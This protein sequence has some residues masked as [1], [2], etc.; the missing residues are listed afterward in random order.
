MGLL[1]RG[2]RP[3]RTLGHAVSVLYSWR[4]FSLPSWNLV[5]MRWDCIE[6][7]AGDGV[8]L[9]CFHFPVSCTK[10]QFQCCF[11]MNTKSCAEIQTP[12]GV[13]FHIAEQPS[14]EQV[15]DTVLNSGG[16]ST[17]RWSYAVGP[18]VSPPPV[19]PFDARSPERPGFRGIIL[20]RSFR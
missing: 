18:V 8:N 12:M 11:S 19:A 6:Q 10:V 7:C 15:R 20:V 13:P 17:T 2:T 1:G 5:L 3:H 16:G 9:P 14:V 4:G